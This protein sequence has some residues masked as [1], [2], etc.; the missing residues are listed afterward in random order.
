MARHFCFYFRRIV[1]SVLRFFFLPL[2]LILNL[3]ADFEFVPRTQRIERDRPTTHGLDGVRKSILAN[4][5]SRQTGVVLP[6]T[7][8]R[9]GNSHLCHGGPPPCS[10]TRGRGGQAKQ[11]PTVRRRMI[12]IVNETFW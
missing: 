3:R 4:A 2:T 10:R 11:D 5:R 6:D 12:G 9:R 7:G 1:A 8:P